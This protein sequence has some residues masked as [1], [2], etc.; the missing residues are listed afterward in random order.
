MDSSPK[1]EER[2]FW[3]FFLELVRTLVK[4]IT[5]ALGMCHSQTMTSR[6]RHLNTDIDRVTCPL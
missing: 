5:F 3:F 1:S 6:I 4:L 2:D